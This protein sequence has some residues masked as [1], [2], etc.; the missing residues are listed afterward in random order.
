MVAILHVD[1]RI[2]AVAARIGQ[3][4][5]GDASRIRLERQSQDVEHQVDVFFQFGR[6]TVRQRQFRNLL[7]TLFGTSDSQ[8]E[9]THAGQILVQFTTI[10]TTQFGFNAFCIRTDKIQNAFAIPI[11]AFLIGCRLRTAK[12]TFECRAR[13]HFFGTRSCR[14][15]PGNVGRVSTAVA[16][17]T[18]PGIATAINPQFNR[19]QVGLRSNTFRNRLINRLSYGDVSSGSFLRLSPRQKRAGVASMVTGPVAIRAGVVLSESF[20]DQDVVFD[21]GQR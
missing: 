3:H 14:C 17:V 15:L 10:G 21:L 20:Q 6:D 1:V 5:R 16:G 2:C 13:I 18:I 11:A 12:Q 8:F 19:R 9:I 4:H 7:R